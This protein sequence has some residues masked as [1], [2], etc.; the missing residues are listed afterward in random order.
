MPIIKLIFAML[1]KQTHGSKLYYSNKSCGCDKPSVSSAK[2][3][4]S[5]WTPS[6]S[7]SKNKSPNG[8]NMRYATDH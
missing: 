5:I 8:L 2:I 4:S 6:G 3:K 1:I 7:G